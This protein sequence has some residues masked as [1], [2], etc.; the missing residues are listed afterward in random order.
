MVRAD[1]SPHPLDEL[2]DADLLSSDRQSSAEFLEA[3]WM[4]S[5]LVHSYKK[6]MQQ[7]VILRPEN[8][9]NVFFSDVTDIVT[10]C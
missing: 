3:D 7:A 9:N 5:M 2:F 6:N 8:E 4:A 10:C 1:S